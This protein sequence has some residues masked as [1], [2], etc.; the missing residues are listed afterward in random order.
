MTLRIN[1]NVSA[2]TAH[3]NLLRNDKSLSTTIEKLSSGKRIN[4]GADGPASLMVSEQ[5]RAQIAGVTQAIDN[6]ESAIS[7]AQTTEAN[8]NEVSRTL[9]SMRQL[10]VHASNE[11]VNNADMLEADQKEFTNGLQSIDRIASNAQFGNRMLLDGSN[12]ATGTT[13]GNQLEFIGAGRQTKSSGDKGFEVRVLKN[14][15]QAHV[16][17]T[18][19][20]TKELID[21]GQDL[22]LI[23]NGKTASYHTQKGDTVA[24]VVMHLNSEIGRNGLDLQVQADTAG[25][26]QVRHNQFGSRPSFE[27]TGSTA[28]ILSAQAG[29]IE[30]AASGSDVTGR[31]NNESTLGEGQV[32]T[33]APGA[34][35]VSGLSV[36][37]KGK[38][39][40][41]NG[42]LPKDGVEVGRVY[43]SQ[44]ALKFQV[45]GNFGQS[46]SMNVKD[47]HTRQFGKSVENQ[48]GYQS[49]ADIDLQSFQG[50]Q[51]ALLLMDK[52][53]AEVSSLRGDLGAFQKNTLESNL[54]N[55]RVANENL[56]SSESVLRDTDIAA[57]MAVYTKGQIMSQA[58]TA[59]LAQA[60]QVSN[61]V[62]RL[63]E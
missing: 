33:G 14:A 29:A 34:Q 8:L 56:I 2:L 57:E 52:A 44:H 3:R 31:I 15:T 41:P 19:A 59:M 10:A 54:S 18:Q 40:D 22:S 17:G 61:Q 6:S 39:G 16:F 53:I 47:V 55:L 35:T 51:D 48:S 9:I 62:L 45:G 38:V 25:H 46:V 63:L 1:T 28:G 26:I 58:S 12:G 50:A 24:Q 37:V 20:L 36:K 32:L 23:E 30:V 13:S 21:Q 27:V 7:M 42:E 49:I 11:G 4:R 60:N 5:M 43:L